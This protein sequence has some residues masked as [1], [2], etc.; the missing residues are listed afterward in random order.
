MRTITLRAAAQAAAGLA[1][2]LWGASLG[3]APSEQVPTGPRAIAMGGAFSAVAD[4][5]SALFWNPAGLAL[6][7]HQEIAGNYAD[8]FGTGIVDNRIAFVLPLAPSHT[9][10]LDWYHSGFEDSELEFGENRFSLSY[11]FRPHP[12]LAVGATAKY[13]T[14]TTGLDGSTV[15]D[16]T[17]FGAD[18]GILAHAGRGFRFALV[19]Q[20]V[21]DT[22][23]HYSDGGPT[24]AAFPRNLRWAAA[25]SYRNH[26]TL[27]LDLDDRVHLGA[28][29]LPLDQV[30]LRAGFQKDREGNEDPTWSFGAG[31]KAGI[32]RL[33]YAYEIHPVLDNTSHFG[34][35]L[36]FH[37]NPSQIR[38]ESVQSQDVYASLYRTYTDTPIGVA[39]VRN[40]KD[41][42]LT[43]RLSVF[44]PGVMNSPTER[45]IVLRPKAV[46]DV[47]LTAVFSDDIMAL[48]G[49]RPVQVEV[50]ASYKSARVM[51]TDSAKG[52]AVL[53]EPGAINLGGGAPRE[54]GFL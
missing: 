28:E 54:P 16:G 1:L 20:D 13:L 26:G 21:F 33:D 53:Y 18:F 39:R 41:E 32:F 35:S 37:F 6:I 27:A 43:A 9:A 25:Y 47:P 17:G 19:G 24:A 7:G 2:I 34:F 51:R 42:P 44:V 12:R 36:A 11:G 29:A 15:R 52:K 48:S 23:L 46:Q 40:L 4:D 22:E 38:I 3:A 10:G 31:F 8:L 45:E 14:R 50:T 49:D 5:A 30:A